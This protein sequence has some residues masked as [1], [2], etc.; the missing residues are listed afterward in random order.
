M[1]LTAIGHAQ[2]RAIWRDYFPE[3]DAIVFMVD[4]AD[5]ERLE[6]AKVVC[7]TGYTSNCLLA[8]A[9]ITGRP[10]FE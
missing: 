7:S 10:Q 4:S 5:T 9:L 2:V 6:E 3:A 8:V 1:I